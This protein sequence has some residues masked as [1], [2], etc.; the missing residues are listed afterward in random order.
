[1][2][3]VLEIGN[4]ENQDLLGNQGITESNMFVYMGMIEQ[5][6][7]ET[8]EKYVLMQQKKGLPV[9]SMTEQQE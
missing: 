8:L 5:K 6:I 4:S 1:M 2:A 9:Y 3:S 7:N